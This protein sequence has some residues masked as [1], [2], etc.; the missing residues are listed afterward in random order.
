MADLT[1]LVGAQDALRAGNG[2]DAMRH[3]STFLVQCGCTGAIDP[4]N[5][6]LSHD[7]NTCPIHESVETTVL[8]TVRLSIVSVAPD[9]LV[10]DLTAMGYSPTEIEITP[11]S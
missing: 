3:I 8:R 6:A 5:G 10:G 1:L 9:E 7:G 4:V 11:T 2:T